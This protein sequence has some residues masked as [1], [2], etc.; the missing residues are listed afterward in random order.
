MQVCLFRLDGRLLALDG[1]VLKYLEAL[2]TEGLRDAIILVATLE[3]LFLALWFRLHEVRVF[4][5][6]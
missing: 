6:I 4:F 5:V 2:H 1:L 3:G